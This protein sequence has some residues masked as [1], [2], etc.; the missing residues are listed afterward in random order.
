MAILA[1]YAL[2]DPFTRTLSIPNKTIQLAADLVLDQAQKA[3]NFETK[4]AGCLRLLRNISLALQ[5][6]ASE[7]NNAHATKVFDD[8]LTMK[9]MIEIKMPLNPQ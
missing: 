6:G 5:G 1:E 9:N 3:Q 2:A 7:D 8:C 4:G